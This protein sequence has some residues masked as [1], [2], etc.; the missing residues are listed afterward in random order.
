[1]LVLNT[2]SLNK[3]LKKNN[4][5][6]GGVTY[7]SGADAISITVKYRGIIPVTIKASHSGIEISVESVTVRG[8]QGPPTLH[9]ALTA[10]PSGKYA[11]TV[12]A[13]GETVNAAITATATTF[14][15]AIDATGLAP[16]K[17]NCAGEAYTMDG[18]TLDIT[19]IDKADDW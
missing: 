8:P 12:S 14:S 11:G 10:G 3:A 2:N 13:L 1:M 9:F 5:V 6:L 17:L 19:N 18:S 4:L 7:D 15:I 16:V